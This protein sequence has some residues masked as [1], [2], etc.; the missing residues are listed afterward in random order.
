[1]KF[2]QTLFLFCLLIT[3]TFANTLT[4]TVDK[5][6]LAPGEPL[7]LTIISS[8]PTQTTPPDFSP[9][10]RDFTLLGNSTNTS[11]S[12]INGATTSHTEWVLTLSPKTTGK[13]TIP[14]LSVGNTQTNPLQVNV[15][16]APK[17]STTTVSSSVFMEADVDATKPL[18]QTQVIYTIRLFFA[19]NLS[20]YNMTDPQVKDAI[21][22]DLQ[23]NK[24]YQKKINGHWYEVYER[25][26]A[27]FPQ[28]VGTLEIQSPIFSALASS[29]NQ[30]QPYGPFAINGGKPITIS[31]PLV[32]LEVQPSLSSGSTWLAVKNLELSETWSQPAKDHPLGTPLERT[33]TLRATGLTAQLLPTL[34]LESPSGFNTYPAKPTQDNLVVQN[35]IVGIYTQKIVYIPTQGGKLRIPAYSLRWY[36][37]TTHQWQ[38]ATLP[39]KTV[40]VVGAAVAT[41]A[42]IPT[43][44]TAK[45][46]V[47]DKNLSQTLKHNL[48][49]IIAGL[50]ILLSL[51]VFLV[52][53]RPRPAT[54]KKQTAPVTHAALKK[55]LRKA[56]LNNDKALAHRLLV[57]YLKVFN[58]SVEASP[59]SNLDQEIKHLQAALYSATPHAWQ[60]EALWKALLD[61]H[62][63][64]HA[65]IRTAPL[66]PLYSNQSNP[67][68]DES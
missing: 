4:A 6:D 25:K 68:E 44:T 52:S 42:I 61:Y 55:Q 2:I 45:S 32:K 21:T 58:V 66:P 12:I 3:P 28:K 26:Y 13:I 57:T 46:A 15:T 10:M 49:W 40:T 50:S 48:P 64:Q 19:E 37:T 8:D 23:Q 14:A 18:L 41:P 16:A 20:N 51:T 9:L 27:I 39:E 22:M 33:L 11:I 31:A 34:T 59:T 7:Q 62:R 1:M 56:C 30:Y 54:P 5:T 47:F 43:K 17:K 60:G 53:R 38:T 29:P 35:N 63:N 24:Q 36:D 65:K 67:V